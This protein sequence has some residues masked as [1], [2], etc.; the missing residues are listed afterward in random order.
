L[1]TA[2]RLLAPYQHV[3]SLLSY[4]RLSKKSCSKS[5]TGL[6]VQEFDNTYKK[7]IIKR[8]HKHE[9]KWLSKRKENRERDIGAG[10]HFKLDTRDRFLM[11]LVYYHLHIS[12]LSL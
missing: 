4:E 8:Y 1:Q 5:F 3:L 12:W 11:L 10:R 2:L 9:I 6:T 7:E